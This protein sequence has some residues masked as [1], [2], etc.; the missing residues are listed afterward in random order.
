MNEPLSSSP[1]P[2]TKAYV[3]VSPASGSVVESVP[4]AVPIGSFSLTLDFDK[5]MSVG[6][7]L[8]TRVNEN[9]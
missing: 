9:T 6:G 5:A 1:A 3:N 2:A 7:R 8:A 4:T